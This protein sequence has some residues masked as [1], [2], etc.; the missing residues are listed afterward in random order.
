MYQISHHGAV[1]GVTGSCH[2]LTLESGGS[3]LVDCGMFQGAESSPT[4]PGQS[5]IDFDDVRPPSEKLSYSYKVVKLEFDI[6][7]NGKYLS[8]NMAGK[9][10]ADQEREMILRSPRFALMPPTIAHLRAHS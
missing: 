6:A 4:K 3:I 8:G 10:A 1:T 9:A 5:P 7:N 2:R